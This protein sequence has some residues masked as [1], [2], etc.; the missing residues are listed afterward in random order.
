MDRWIDEKSIKEI[1]G[2][3]DQLGVII[4]NLILESCHVQHTHMQGEE[5]HTNTTKIPKGQN[6]TS[7]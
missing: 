3:C 5:L 2:Y 7:I 4:I 1:I 6:R